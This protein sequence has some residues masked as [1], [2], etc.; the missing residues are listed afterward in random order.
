M[1]GSLANCN[2]PLCCRESSGNVTDP[3]D[4]AGYWGDYR[5]CD[6]PWRTIESAVAHMAQQHNVIK[7]SLF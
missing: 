6:M 2:D 1:E 5:N 4:A 3:A 7:S